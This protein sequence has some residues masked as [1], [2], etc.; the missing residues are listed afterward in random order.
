MGETLPEEPGEYSLPSGGFMVPHP[1]LLHELE[2]ARSS[3]YE[4][5]W[6][7][8]EGGSRG[9]KAGAQILGQF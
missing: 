5:S 9:R 4:F 2:P 1:G 7:T 6:C 8:E 3:L